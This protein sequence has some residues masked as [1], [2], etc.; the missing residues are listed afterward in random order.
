MAYLWPYSEEWFL[1]VKP[2]VVLPLS[3]TLAIA[4]NKYR[5]NL[6]P[7]LLLRILKNDFSNYSIQKLASGDMP[8]AQGLQSHA[9]PVYKHQPLVAYRPFT[10]HFPCGMI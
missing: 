1:A 5:G 2:A 9:V 4:C 7:S 10:Q 6:L 8:D 3:P